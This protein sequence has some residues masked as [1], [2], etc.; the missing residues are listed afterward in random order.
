[1]SRIRFASR[2]KG[3]AFMEITLGDLRRLRLMYPQSIEEQS[4]IADILSQ[5]DVLCLQY[6]HSSANCGP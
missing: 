4:H 1:M 2:E 6:S 5:Q 3:T